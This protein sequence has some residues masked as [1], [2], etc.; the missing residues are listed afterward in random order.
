M[1]LQDASTKT[2]EPHALLA[3]KGM[4]GRLSLDRIKRSSKFFLLK[5]LSY[6][7]LTLFELRATQRPLVFRE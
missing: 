7:T 4:R 3:P 5:Q 1:T 2:I 6:F